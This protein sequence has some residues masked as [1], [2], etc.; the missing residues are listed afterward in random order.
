MGNDITIRELAQVISETVGYQGKI[1]FDASKPDGALR[2]L[3]DSSRLRA[4]G[5]YPK[6]DLIQGLNLAYSDYLTNHF[7]KKRRGE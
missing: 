5:W 4:M 6:L 7:A 1:L 2:K 3:M